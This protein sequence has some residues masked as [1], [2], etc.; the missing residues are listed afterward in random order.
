M[1][2]ALFRPFTVV[3]AA[4]M[5]ALSSACTMKS[6]E[7]PPLSGPSEFDLSIVLAASPDQLQQ[8]GASQSLITVTA[9]D[10]GSQPVRN[11]SLRAAMSVQG[12]PMDFGSLSARSV[13]T[14]N[15]GRAQFVYTAPPSPAVAPDN[16]IVVDIV[17]TPTG[18]DFSNTT[19]RVVSIRLY[20]QGPVVPNPNLIPAFTFDPNSPQ[21]NQTVLFDA[22]SS[23][24]SITTWEWRFGDGGRGSGRTTSHEY[25]T[26]NTYV[27][28]LIVGDAF[29]RT[30]QTSRSITVGQ[31][32]AP[33]A[34]FSF[35]PTI[36]LPGDVVRFNASAS[37]PA[38]GRTIVSYSWD[39]GD[40]ATATGISASHPYGVSNTYNVT[41]N[42][43]DD[44][45]RQGTVSQLVTV[46]KP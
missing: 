42:V 5:L 12:T 39:F 22:S 29:G 43:V 11:L 38:P 15:D 23:Q 9:R 40:G 45:G 33:T 35:S 21:E 10:S 19:S 37:R 2:R 14:G 3:V 26:A 36:P 17:V 41:L 28:T 27:V 46:N 18:T 1:T 13:V 31:G 4:G 6:Q 16:F 25:S 8:D 32:V 30:E 44:A 20:P 7:P 34:A 24:G